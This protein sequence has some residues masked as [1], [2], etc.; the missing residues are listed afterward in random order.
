MGR[1]QP[2]KC[3]LS[4]NAAG[5]KVCRDGSEWSTPGSVCAESQGGFRSTSEAFLTKIFT[6]A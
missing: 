4:R 3:Q 1:G 5:L 2:L 6:L